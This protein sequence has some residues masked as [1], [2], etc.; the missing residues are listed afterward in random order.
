MTVSEEAREIGIE[1]GVVIDV[2]EDEGEMRILRL[3]DPRRRLQSDS[4]FL[5]FRR[6]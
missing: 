3:C 1:R 5:T 4:D 2:N 6:K